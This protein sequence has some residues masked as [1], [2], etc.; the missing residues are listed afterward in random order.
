MKLNF[1]FLLTAIMAFCLLGTSLEATEE[2]K[3]AWGD[4]YDVYI[5]SV[6]CS[7]KQVV[8]VEIIAQTDFTEAFS[9]FYFLNT[10]KTL[11]TQPFVKE[12]EPAPPPRFYITHRSL[13]I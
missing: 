11:S 10:Y 3:D 13:L 8:K 5:P 4:E 6:E 1:R 7:F 9:F 12:L 2:A